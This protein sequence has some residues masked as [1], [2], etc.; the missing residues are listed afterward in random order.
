VVLDVVEV[1]VC[2]PALTFHEAPDGRP[3]SWNVTEYLVGMN[4]YV[5]DT[6]VELVT[7]PWQLPTHW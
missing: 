1:P 6:E 7:E 2:D 5:T 3:V 4:V